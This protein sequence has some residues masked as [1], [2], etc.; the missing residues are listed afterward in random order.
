MLLTDKYEE[1]QVQLEALRKAS[2]SIAEAEALQRQRILELNQELKTKSYLK[3]E[4]TEGSSY[5]SRGGKP[6]RTTKASTVEKLRGCVTIMADP[7]MINKQKVMYFQ[8]LGPDMNVIEDNANTINVNGNVYSK[9]VE[10]IFM[11]EEIQVCDV[12]TIP[13]G[14][15]PSGTY[16]LNIFE[17]ERLLD[18]GEFQLK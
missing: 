11:G 3:I 4:A 2:S 15:L 6:I 8:F 7:T 16:I 12:I 5:R 1:S 13:E 10:L 18:S 17:N 9:R 14:S